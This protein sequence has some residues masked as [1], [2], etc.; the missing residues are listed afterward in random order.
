MC[1]PMILS[2][3]WQSNAIISAIAVPAL[4]IYCFYKLLLKPFVKRKIKLQEENLSA[5]KR[6]MAEE[7][8]KDALEAVELMKFTAARTA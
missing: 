8:K 4:S 5:Q 2:H 7:R 6:G 3:E 1:I